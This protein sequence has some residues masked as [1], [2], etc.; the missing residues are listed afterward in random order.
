LPHADD[1][2]LKYATDQMHDRFRI[3]HVTLQV[4]KS[5]FTRACAEQT[6]AEAG[7][8]DASATT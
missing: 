3:I 7:A 4:M 6:D 8:M 1:A 2:F 5:P